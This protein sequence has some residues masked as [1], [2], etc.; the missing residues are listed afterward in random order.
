ML[1]FLGNI[2]QLVFSPQKGWEDLDEDD[3]RSDGRRGRI[4]IRR[5]YTRCFLPLIAICSATSFTR[6]LFDGGPDFLGALQMAII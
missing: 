3:Y 2:I 1:K 4:D 5:L 6:M